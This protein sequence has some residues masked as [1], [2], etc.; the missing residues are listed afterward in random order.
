MLYKL[1][2]FSDKSTPRTTTIFVETGFPGATS[3]FER[4]SHVCRFYGD[5]YFD[6]GEEEGDDDAASA[7]DFST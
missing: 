3:F 7:A 1:I 6:E 2:K 5:Y 4:D